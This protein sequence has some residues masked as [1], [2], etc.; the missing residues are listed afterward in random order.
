MLPSYAGALWITELCWTWGIL[1]PATPLRAPEV[2]SGFQE[3]GIS[4]QAYC[5]TQCTAWGEDTRPRG[6]LTPLRASSSKHCLALPGWRREAPSPS[7]LLCVEVV[8]F[9]FQQ[10]TKLW[11]Q[12]SLARH[13]LAVDSRAPKGWVLSGF[14]L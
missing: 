10:G 6:A 13:Q 12:S 7:G 11:L 9:G 5:H 2:G 3:A 8:Y 1:K 4:S 14:S